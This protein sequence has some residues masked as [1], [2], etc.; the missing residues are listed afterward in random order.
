MFWAYLLVFKENMAKNYYD[1]LGVSKTASDDEIKKAYRGLAK[2]YHP[3]LNPGNNEAAEKLK[4]VNEAFSVLSDKTKRQ[5]YDTYGSADGPQGFGGAGGGFGG[6]G[7]FGDFGDI[8]SSFFGGGGFGGGSRRSRAT[9]PMQG[10]DIQVKVKLSFVE[11]AFGCKKSINLVRSESCPD[12]HGTGAKNGAYDTCPKCSGNG[13]IRQA[14]NTPFGQVVTEGVCP[15]CHGTGKKIKEKCPKCNGNGST[16][17]NRTIEINIPGGIGNEQI[18]TL[19]GQGEAGRNGGS[20][21]DMQI[22]IQVENH[23]LLKREGFDVFVDVPIS[24][25]EALLGGKVKV[26]GINE[27]LDLTIPELTQTGTILTIKGKGTK[28]LNKQA[29]GDLYAKVVVE[30]PKSLDKK[31][32]ELIKQLDD[33]IAR[34]QYSK[35]K[36]FNDKL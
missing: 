16:R 5:N 15:D 1:I 7:D 6:F 12:C 10:D 18:L 8:F 25:T 9:Q 3:D 34:N 20:A 32:K 14:Q 35:K 27:T 4:E 13:T 22:L 33:G 11:A 36:Q 31:Q 30:M 24:F 28:V 19:R 21:G 26:P 2:K 17:E 29:Y 23:K